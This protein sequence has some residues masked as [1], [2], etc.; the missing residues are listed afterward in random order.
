[1]GVVTNQSLH[2]FLDTTSEGLSV[3]DTL[4]ART[5]RTKVGTPGIRPYARCAL[6]LVCLM[7][8]VTPAFLFAL[9]ATQYMMKLLRSTRSRTMR[10]ASHYS[11]RG[12]FNTS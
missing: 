10:Q 8:G 5:A 2:S 12:V 7:S 1:M 9:S 6:C 11:Q 4:S 3:V